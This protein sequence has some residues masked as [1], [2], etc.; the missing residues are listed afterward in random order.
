M[1]FMAAALDQDG[2]H[3]HDDDHDHDHTDAN[4]G[5]AGG[6]DSAAVIVD[7]YTALLYYQNA[8]QDHLRWNGQVDVGTQVVVTY[9]FIETENLPTLAEYDPYSAD[10]YWSFSEANRAQLRLVMDQYEAV[11][12]VKFVEVEGE[13]MINVMG[14][15]VTGAGGWANVSSAHES[16]VGTGYF[17]NAYS[18]QAAGQYGYQVNLHELGHAMGLQHTFEGDFQL[19]GAVDNQTNTVM[20]YNIEYPYVS[21]LGTFDVQA[22][23]DIY[24]G[25]DS[26]DG[27]T[28]SV[29]ENDIVT[30]KATTTISN[31]VIVGTNVDTRIQAYNGDDEILGRQGNDTLNGGN[32]DDTITGG[33]GGDR[34]LGRAGEDEMYGDVSDAIY[35][36]TADDNDKMYGGA[37][38]DTMHGGRGD[39]LVNG[40][41]DNDLLFGDYGNDTLRGSSG[42]DTLSG[43]DGA[44]RLA[45]G[46]GADVFVFT[47][48]DSYE[49]DVITDFSDGEDLVDM[50]AF[51]FSDINQFTLT[52]VGNSTHLEYSNWIDI[53]FLRTDVSE[54]SNSDF[55]FS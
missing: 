27:W 48:Y 43:G 46:S 9:S 55:I 25:A 31:D 36:G 41:K 30:I 40:A 24:G 12:G 11:S 22:M 51:S 13:G 16:S 34:L 21:A 39:D 6:G 23:E 19:N 29:D 37:G 8:G 52:Q 38:D 7:D 4:G 45:G 14:A 3:D 10:G 32:G 42:D 26:F 15:D 47:S 2:T 28:V 33:A 44:D 1:E 50:S 20:T 54:L 5:D 17:V 53:V 35:G 49:L 18:T